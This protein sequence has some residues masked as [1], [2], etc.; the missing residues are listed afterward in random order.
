MAEKAQKNDLLIG[1]HTSIAGGLEN[2]LYEGASIGCTCIQIFTHSNRQWGMP[3]LT[4]ESIIAFEKARQA[5]GIKNIM[6]HASYLINIASPDALV[7]K[8][9]ITAL[10]DELIRCEA[11]AIPL[12][13]MHPGSATHRPRD[14]ALEQILK[15]VSAVFEQVPFHHTLLLFEN[16]A[17]QGSVLG[18]SIEELAYLF[19]HI[20]PQKRLGICIDTCHAFAAGYALD[21]AQGYQEFWDHFDKLIGLK[22]LKALHMNDSQ[23]ARGA[24]VDRHA[25]IGK[26]QLGAATF[27]RIMHDKRFT[28]IPKIL[29]TPRNDIQDHAR[30]LETLRQLA[31]TG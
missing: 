2:A 15:N 3:P 29:E 21:T 11:L 4:Q 5:T 7:E 1:A 12:L 28:D 14:E 31:A 13:V 26:G 6:V 24:R 16:M 17:G 18:S 25:D 20:K 19:F 8:K 27:Q 9:S 10:R 30:N 23:R 22:H